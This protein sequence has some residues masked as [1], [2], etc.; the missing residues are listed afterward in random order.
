M[1]VDVCVYKTMSRTLR[2]ETPC[3]LFIGNF[4]TTPTVQAETVAISVAGVTSVL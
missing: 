4:A 1:Y 3:F 2:I